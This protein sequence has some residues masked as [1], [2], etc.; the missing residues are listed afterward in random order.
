M[1]HIFGLKVLLSPVPQVVH[2]VSDTSKRSITS[3]GVLMLGCLPQENSNFEP[4]VSIE[5]LLIS[6]SKPPKK[7]NYENTF[8]PAVRSVLLSPQKERW[9]SGVVKC[10]ALDSQNDC[11]QSCWLYQNHPVFVL[12]SQKPLQSQVD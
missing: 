6:I 8:P 12:W 11:Y 3:Q 7:R 10:F 5:R 2:C 4:C 1:G 9:S